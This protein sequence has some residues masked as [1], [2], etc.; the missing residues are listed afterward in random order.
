MNTGIESEIVTL[1]GDD[2]N[3][4]QTSRLCNA[5]A[6]SP[7]DLGDVLEALKGEGKLLGFAG[8][9]ISPRGFETGKR[10]LMHALQSHHELNPAVEAFRPQEI[11]SAAGL[12]WDGKPLSRILT[13]FA[14]DAPIEYRDG[15]LCLRTFR[16][17]LSP[18]KQALLNRILAELEREPV[19]T[20]PPI[21]IAKALGIPIQAVQ[22]VLRLAEKRLDVI[23]VASNVYYTP[24]QLSSLKQLVETFAKGKPFST[25]ELRDELNTTRKY[26]QPLLDYFDSI[27]FTEKSGDRRSVKTL[28]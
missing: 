20:P 27:G 10:L 25:T 24:A 11:V 6:R 19:S 16:L 18:R 12:K 5:L 23:E 22:E 21:A 9:W 26:V 14:A 17:T 7:Q 13:S 4:I 3:G 28:N 8:L 2:P 1:V 15:G